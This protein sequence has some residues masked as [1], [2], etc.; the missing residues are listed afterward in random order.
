MNKTRY[1]VYK[2]TIH[3]IFVVKYRRKVFTKDALSLLEKVFGRTCE[4]LECKFDRIWG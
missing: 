1:L 3:M 4:E 2:L